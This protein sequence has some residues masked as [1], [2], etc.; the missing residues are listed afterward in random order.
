[1]E[2]TSRKSKNVGLSVGTSSILVIFVLLCLTTFATLSMVSANAD[3]KLTLRSAEAVREYYAADARA[4]EV[5][6]ELSTAFQQA[7]EN[8][9]ATYMIGDLNS[10]G[11]VTIFGGQQEDGSHRLWY[12]VP[13][14][15]R[16]V[17]SV[18]LEMLPEPTPEDGFM[19]RLE[20][21]VINLP[22]ES[23]VDEAIN[24]LWSGEDAFLPLA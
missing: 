8:N 10:V 16:Q 14:N 2:A 22:D 7:Y 17:L 20:W 11:E 12:E 23:P 13:V 1:M 9:P 24:S 18:I 19:K 21:K 3:Y 5:Y 6:A 4:E 15:D